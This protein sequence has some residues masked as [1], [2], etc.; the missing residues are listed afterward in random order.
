MHSGAVMG[1]ITMEWGA[2]LQG[3]LLVE[4]NVLFL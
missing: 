2:L 1:K 3:G 4:R